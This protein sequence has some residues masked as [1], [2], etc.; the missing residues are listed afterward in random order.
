[1]NRASI[2]PLTGCLLFLAAF[3]AGCGG[4][5][6]TVNGDKP[7]VLATSVFKGKHPIQV[8]CTTGM[9]ADIVRNIGGEHVAVT[10]LMKA[11][12]DPHLYKASPS[13]IAELGRADLIVYSGLHLEG[14]LAQLFDDMAAKK[15]TYAVADNLD[16]AKLLSVAEGYHD[17]HV[18]FD[19]MLWR[20]AASGFA[21]VLAKFDPTHVA[22]YEANAKKYLQELEELD[23]ECREKLAAITADRRVLVTAHDAFEYFGKAYDID[24][25]A[26]QGVSTESEAGLRKINELVDFIV[27]RKIK[28]VFVETSVAD[29]NIQSL[30]E[31][32]RA[33]Q[34]EVVIGGELFSDAMG[35]SGTPEGTYIGMVRRNVRTIA[36]A[37]K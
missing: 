14:K 26:I 34:H 7:N 20:D 16:E 9:V 27:Q 36:K 5:E 10:Q 13:D 23:A 6:D 33:K 12:V 32:C 21:S 18:W 2:T 15:P 30:V 3:S 25:R 8:V 28:A 11:E 29:R 17:P 1:M 19:V 37:L 35:K 31:G 22:D 24:V 4:G